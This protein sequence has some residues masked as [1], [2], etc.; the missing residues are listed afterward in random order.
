MLPPLADDYY[1]LLGVPTGADAEE[2]RKAW[3]QLALQWHPDRAGD[4]ATA[5]FQQLSA[6][7]AVLSDPVARAAY[8][9]RRRAAEPADDGASAGASAPSPAATASPPRPAQAARRQAPAVMLSRLSGPIGSLFACGVARRDEPGFITLVLSED[10]AAQGGMA[11]ISMRVD[12]WCTDCAGKERSAGCASCDGTRAVDKLYSA[13]LAVPPGV[14]AGEVLTP[15]VDLPGMITPVRF[16][17]QIHGA[18]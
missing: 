11:T 1:A 8:D 2:L 18:K 4:A 5:R 10:E 6:A 17:V 16:R 13:W 3:R 14:T 12:V 15:S 7:Y 9:R